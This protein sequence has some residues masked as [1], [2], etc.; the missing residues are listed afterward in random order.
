MN[1]ILIFLV[2]L[3]LEHGLNAETNPRSPVGYQRQSPRSASAKG[4]DPGTTNLAASRDRDLSAAAASIPISATD[5]ILAGVVLDD[6]EQPVEGASVDFAGEGEHEGHGQTDR[7]GRFFFRDVGPGL[8]RISASESKGGHGISDGKVGD[9]NLVIQ[10]GSPWRGPMVKEK[11]S[12]RIPGVVRDADGKPAPK[13]RLMVLP[14][15]QGEITTDA[16]GR[17]SLFLDAGGGFQKLGQFVVFAFD[18]A[19]HWAATLDLDEDTTNADLRLEPTWTLAGRVIDAGGSAITNAQAELV[20]HGAPLPAPYGSLVAVDRD[21]RFE[22]KGLPPARSFGVNLTGKGYGR[23]YLRVDTPDAGINR[24]EAEPVKLIAANLPLGG[25]VLDNK[26]RP[27]IDALVQC[28]GEGQPIG[29]ERSDSQG[30]FL[31]QGTCPGR[32]HIT[33]KASK[34]RFAYVAAEAGDTHVVVR[35]A[36]PRQN[37][38][39]GAQARP[40]ING[41]VVD[42]DDQPARNVRLVFLPHSYAD[43]WT[44]TQGRFSLIPN[45][46]WLGLA[47]ES[48]AVLALDPARNLAASLDLDEQITNVSLKLEPAWTCSGR[49]TD[50]GGAPVMNARVQMHYSNNSIGNQPANLVDGQVQVRRSFSQS[51]PPPPV[52]LGQPVAVD[53]AGRFSFQ[54]LPPGR[55]VAVTV[56]ARGYGNAYLT[57]NAP[58]AG[59]ERVETDPIRLPPANLTVG[60]L[61]LDDQDR[62]ARGVTVICLS[63]GLMG[64]QRVTDRQGRF[65]FQ[66]V[67]PGRLTVQASDFSGNYATVEAEGGAT[68]VVLRIQSRERRRIPVVD[69]YR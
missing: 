30:K 5:Q 25:V 58:P 37:P 1:N 18:P 9:T 45:L 40:K 10:L 49:V 11:T 15:E 59:T 67:C 39:P 38:W 46:G 31:V 26:E 36:D 50:P 44:D 55:P 54:P 27:V 64:K 8:V 69:G 24:V 29:E 66:G 7:Q 21:G 53:G 51:H 48:I 65:L 57:V 32:V 13:M 23:S 33:A 42:A 17:F 68:N 3:G 47:G 41:T 52:S 35:F 28:S 14:N 4:Y 19:R 20:F 2:L 63:L 12:L 6:H 61:V 22:I 34:A 62:P 16:Q 56:T 60:G 43:K